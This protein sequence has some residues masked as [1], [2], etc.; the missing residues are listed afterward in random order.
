MAGALLV[1]ELPVR[2]CPGL[3]CAVAVPFWVSLDSPELPVQ[4]G[5]RL[6]YVSAVSVV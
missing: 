2:A 4:V 6:D 3:G 5:P 1:R